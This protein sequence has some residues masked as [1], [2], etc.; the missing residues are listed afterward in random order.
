MSYAK[1]VK[2]EII[3][4]LSDNACCRLAFLN[5]LI[6]SCGEFGLAAR[7][8]SIN[9]KTEFQELYEI[10]NTT[11]KKLYSASADVEAENDA[12]NKATRYC[13]TI[14]GE[15]ATKL[16][17]DCGIARINENNCFE[18]IDSIDRYTLEDVCCKRAF[19]KGIFV[20]CGSISGVSEDRHSTGYH[21]EC[22]FISEQ[23]ATDFVELLSEF[24]IF[25]KKVVRKGMHV[26]YLKSGEQI[27]DVLALCEAG[28]KVI[29]F[30]QHI[31]MRS[32]INSVNRVS[33]CENA[34]INKTV[35]SC[36]AQLKAI[37]VIQETIGLDA[38]NEDLASLCN[39]RLANQEESLSELCKLTGMTK[40]AI[41]YRFNKILKIAKELSE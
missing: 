12:F 28:E 23:I 26:V 13:I 34:N 14:S 19:V 33:N 32:I 1:E 25:C 18:L 17:L 30:N 3:D 29:E 4:G 35:E 41:N 37:E 24:D 8:I 7:Q 22:C 15:V 11:L 10:I 40:S 20:G 31:A 16:L 39:L 2:K 9:I 21:F 38:L 27:S 6:R 36:L 5:A